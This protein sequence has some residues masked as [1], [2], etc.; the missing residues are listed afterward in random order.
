MITK[1]CGSIAAVQIYNLESERSNRSD[2]PLLSYM[3]V[4]PL[5]PDSFKYKDSLNKYPA[6][7]DGGATNALE[8]GETT[9]ASLHK[10][11]PIIKLRDSSSNNDSAMQ[12]SDGIASLSELSNTMPTD[13][14]LFAPFNPRQSS[15][16]L[17]IA[18][19]TEVDDE[20]PEKYANINQLLRNSSKVLQLG[21]QAS[22]LNIST[23]FNSDEIENE[24]LSCEFKYR[25]KCLKLKY[26]YIFNFYWNKIF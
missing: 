26:L 5:S 21:Q 17:H 18:S 4:T 6:N 20:N 8:K 13:P 2:P 11:K 7:E 19:E 24:A 23:D 3:P 22:V 16:N 14:V 1:L 10:W 12:S 25:S 9:A 15:N